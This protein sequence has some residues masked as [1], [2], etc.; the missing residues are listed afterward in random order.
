MDRGSISFDGNTYT[1]AWVYKSISSIT[2]AT[3]DIYNV[4][5]PRTAVTDA[6]T[7]VTFNLPFIL[8][9]S[10]AQTNNVHT[11]ILILSYRF[12]LKI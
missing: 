6:A 10:G 9:N 5:I 3:L 1:H 2:N 12:C 11:G 8:I 7:F 4:P